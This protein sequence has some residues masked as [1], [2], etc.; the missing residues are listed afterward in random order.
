M[1][2]F[3]RQQLKHNRQKQRAIDYLKDRGLSGEIARD[4][5]IGY[6]PSGWDN[7]L[8]HL[9]ISQEDKQL[10]IDGGMLIEEA[11][12]KLYDLS[13]TGLFSLFVITV[14]ELLPLVA[15]CWGMINRNTSTHRKH[16]YFTKA[17]SCMAFTSA[18][19]PTAN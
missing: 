15:V 3:Y 16:R 7:L 2:D 5:D 17:K 11:D 8:K 6:A 1:R 12:N 10:L 14:D 4:F 18:V 13:V 19:K 9:G